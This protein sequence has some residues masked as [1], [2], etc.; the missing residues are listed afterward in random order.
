[1]IKRRTQALPTA[2]LLNR[3]AGTANKLCLRYVAGMTVA[4]LLLIG[5]LGLR[6]H[7]NERGIC[8]KEGRTLSASELRQRVIKSYI[9]SIIQEKKTLNKKLFSRRVVSISSLDLGPDELQA[10]ANK[11]RF[12]NKTIAE[13]F[14][15]KPEFIDP[16][17]IDQAIA[18]ATYSLVEYDPGGHMLYIT[19]P[20]SIQAVSQP[21]GIAQVGWL[22]KLMG[23]GNHF[24]RYKRKYT[25]LACCDNLDFTLGFS[26]ADHYDTLQE[27][28]KIPGPYT[29]M[30]ASNCGDVQLPPND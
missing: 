10:I 18:K 9:L 22:D 16:D 19:R 8:V 2:A 21:S 13:N 25:P 20:A 28:L 7:Q 4:V 1:M 6:F 24:Y 27:V 29:V 15:F 23:Y 12:T 30:Q 26:K 5:W 14:A 17:Q 3:Q 11:A